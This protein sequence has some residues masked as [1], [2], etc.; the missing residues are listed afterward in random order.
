MQTP[1]FTAVYRVE[2]VE[3]MAMVEKAM[4]KQKQNKVLLWLDIGEGVVV[5]VAIHKAPSTSLVNGDT[6]LLAVVNL[7]SSYHGIALLGTG[8]AGKRVVVDLTCFQRS[9]ALVVNEN[10][11]IFPI[12][13]LTFA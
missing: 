3:Q 12:V 10:P 2:N 8:D 7:A 11:C 6:T 13:D 4:P 5:D 1:H 9:T